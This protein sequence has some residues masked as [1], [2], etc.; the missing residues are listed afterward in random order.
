[1]QI[2]LQAA[3]HRAPVLHALAAYASI[4]NNVKIKGTYR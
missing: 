1:M 3:G 4:Q 2:F